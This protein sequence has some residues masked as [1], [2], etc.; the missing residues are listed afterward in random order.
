[1]LRESN[2]CYALPTDWRMMPM[3]I[4]IGAG[5]YLIGIIA[6]GLFICK[7]KWRRTK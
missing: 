4:W 2:V 1:M 6:L 5:A 7:D 3:W